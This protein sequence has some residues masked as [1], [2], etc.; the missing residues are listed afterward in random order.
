MK[1]HPA[2]LARSLAIVYVLLIVYASLHPF[3]GWRDSGA[4]IFGYL[5]APWPRYYTGFD[6]ALNVLAYAP[7]GFLLVPTLARL[8]I[9]TAAL[10]AVLIGSGLSFA[11]ETL[12][13]FLPS[14]VPSNIDLACNSLGALIGATAGMNWGRTL[15]DGG[16]LYRLRVRQV[17]S[18]RRGEFGLVL[19]GLWLLALLN[20]QALLFGS[21]DL[22][23]LLE[24]LELP[25]LPYSARRFV[26]LE[27][28]V[29]AAG[30]LCAGLI[31][32]SLLRRPHRRLLIA[33]LLL[34]LLIRGFANAVLVNAA[35]FVQWLTPGNS[36]GLAIGAVALYA[37]TWL[38]ALA[39]RM[40]AAMALMLATALVNLAPENPYLSASL[41][42]WQ[43]GHFF[44]FNGLTRLVSSLWPF[45]ALAY[46][47]LPRSREEAAT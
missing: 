30:L 46:L 7:L 39:Q 14:R 15:L 42:V 5:A 1:E 27:A 32:W 19:L 11:M 28:A 9:F 10:A 35:Q 29:A 22:R 44:N 4:S 12:Q 8:G 23:V 20:P 2:P 24:M 41:A 40:L 31:A 16:R 36:A 37:A 25:A 34:P 17:I 18:G 43:Q 26:A 47:M 3:T 38:P 21:G 6:L 33:F 45:A 13:N